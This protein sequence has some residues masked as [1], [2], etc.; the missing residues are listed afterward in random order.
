MKYV[1]TLS[2]FML[3]S[4]GCQNKNTTSGCYGPNQ[5][6]YKDAKTA[7]LESGFVLVEMKL[8]TNSVKPRWFILIAS[9]VVRLTPLI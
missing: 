5:P 1:I 3:C 7:F 9:L 6:T 4:Y 8:D 2:L